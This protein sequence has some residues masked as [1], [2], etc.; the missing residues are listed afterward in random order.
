MQITKLERSVYLL[1][2]AGAIDAS[3]ASL[4]RRELAAL[5]RAN[6][7]DRAEDGSWYVIRA[8]TD[9]RPPPPGS[10][11]RPAVRPEPMTTLVAKVPETAIAALDAMG[12][13]RSENLRAV[14]MAALKP[15]VKKTG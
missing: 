14:L 3:H 5:R 13:N 9:T 1:I 10:G 11:T 12:P 15:G 7:A 2:E 8:K 6:L 4:Y